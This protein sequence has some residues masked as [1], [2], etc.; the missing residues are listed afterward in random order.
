MGGGKTNAV[1]LG[2]SKDSV[3]DKPVPLDIDSATSRSCPVTAEAA[4]SSPVVPAN[5]S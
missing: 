2:K 4:G 3:K 1:A 5:S